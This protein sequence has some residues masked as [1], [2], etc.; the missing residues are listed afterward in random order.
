MVLRPEL[1][2]QK[3]QHWADTLGVQ[4]SVVAQ[5][6]LVSIKWGLIVPAMF[7]LSKQC[8]WLASPIC[9]VK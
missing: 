5:T 7:G 1:V 6:L 2:S 3:L 9:S 4:R 8:R